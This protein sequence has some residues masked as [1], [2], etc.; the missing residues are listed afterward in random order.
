MR[1]QRLTYEKANTPPTIGVRKSWLSWNTSNLKD[2]EKSSQR[3]FEDLIIRKFI[4]GTWVGRLEVI[5]EV[6]IKRRYNCVYI[7]FIVN[8]SRELLNANYFLKG[9]SEEMLSIILKCPVKCE[10]I[11][12][13]ND[14]LVYGII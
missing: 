7:A 10:I 5:S 8:E 1:K 2:E 9:Y 6:I 11:R 13:T 14:D 4:T 12:A 3:A